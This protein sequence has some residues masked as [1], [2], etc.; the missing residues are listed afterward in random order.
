MTYKIVTF[1][2]QMNISDSQR[3]ATSLEKKGY[4]LNEDDP[5]LVFINVCS[6]RQSAVDRALAVA[7]KYRDKKVIFTGCVIEPNEQTKSLADLMGPNYLEIQPKKD[8]FA[9][10]PIM[11]GCDNYCTYCVVPYTRGR[12]VFRSKQDIIKEVKFFLEDHKEIWL[13]GQNVNSH[14]DFADI[15]KE[16]NDIPGDFWV[17][18]TSSHPKDFNEEIISAM[19]LPK[20]TEYLNLPV[21]SGDNNVLKRM[22]RP[23]NITEYKTAIKKIREAIPDIAISTDV[24]VGFPGETEEE[25]QNTVNLFKEIKYDM[26]YI[27]IY[28]PRPKTPAAKMPDQVPQPEKKR[29][30]DLL[31]DILRQTAL[32]QNQKFIGKELDI[33]VHE[34]RDSFSLGKT[35]HHKTV[36]IPGKHSGFIK[37][38]IKQAKPWGLEA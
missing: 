29:R 4:Q 1:G 19:K 24:I 14:P 30:K 5:D 36:K 9:G 25:F 11:T 16:I 22:N 8:S 23:Y 37:A 32:K 31:N 17:R 2:C 35:R 7:K 10:V 15:L 27:S 38:V 12:E 26:A 21:Q 6:I 18:F 33:L 34:Q 3:L 13:L 20:I 28:S